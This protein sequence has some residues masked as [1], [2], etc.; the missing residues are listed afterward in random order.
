M[1]AWGVISPQV[2]QHLM[3]LFTQDLTT[4]A[5]DS[6]DT[7]GMSTYLVDILA[8]LGSDGTIS[9]NIHRDLIRRLPKSPMPSL[10]YFM[11]PLTHKVLG[12]FESSMCMILPHELFASLYHNY[13]DAFFSYVVPGLDVL[14]DFWDSVKGG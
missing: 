11:N 14:A 6:K 9:G 8:G 12:D 7:W 5:G 1:W 4:L 13:R 3:T 10:H 2:V